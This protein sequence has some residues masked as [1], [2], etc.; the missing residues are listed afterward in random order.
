MYICIYL[1]IDLCLYNVSIFANNCIGSSHVEG[2]YTLDIEANNQG[3]PFATIILGIFN[4]PHMARIDLPVE[5]HLDEA[6]RSL[7]EQSAQEASHQT[8]VSSLPPSLAILEEELQAVIDWQGL[9]LQL[10]LEEYR[11]QEILIDEGGTVAHC[12][13]SMLSVWLKSA[14]TASWLDVVDAL[15]KMGERTLAATVKFRYCQ[16]S[17]VFQHAGKGMDG[18]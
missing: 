14:P 12:R 18:L 2:H 6:V 7:I 5:S 1:F 13:R 17:P 10:G 16:T 8:Q 4:Q 3:L 15:A 9:G 11:L